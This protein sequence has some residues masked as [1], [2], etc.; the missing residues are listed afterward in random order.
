MRRSVLEKSGSSFFRRKKI[1][2]P[3]KDDSISEGF[4]KFFSFIK[5][6]WVCFG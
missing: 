6:V 4:I 1:E 2:L 5:N 3:F